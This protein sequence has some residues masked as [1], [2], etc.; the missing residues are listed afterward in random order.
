VLHL[1]ASV[2]NRTGGKIAVEP[3][4]PLGLAVSVTYRS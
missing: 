3:K 2:V 4:R 1:V